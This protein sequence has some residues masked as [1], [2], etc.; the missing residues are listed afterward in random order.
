MALGNIPE[1][2]CPTYAEER[3]RKCNDGT[4]WLKEECKEFFSTKLYDSNK[5]Y[6]DERKKRCL[7]DTKKAIKKDRKEKIIRKI[8]KTI[9]QK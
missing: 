5:E 6:S 4:H 8:R 1:L 2:E 9:G 3:D 7:E